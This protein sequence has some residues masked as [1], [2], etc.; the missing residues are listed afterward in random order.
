MNHHPTYLSTVPR[1][2]LVSVVQ[3][4]RK[5]EVRCTDEQALEYAQRR[6]DQMERNAEHMKVPHLIN[7]PGAEAIEA[8]RIRQMTEENFQADADDLYRQGE[9]IQAAVCYAREHLG[10]AAGV[11]PWPMRW[12]KP[13]TSREN[14][15]RAGALIAAEIDRLDRAA[16]K[17]PQS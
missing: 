12:W 3:L 14:L 10:W 6:V 4:H 5:Q 8:E 2:Q 1:G 13:R 9:L 16:A 11:W 7:S 15:V 17:R